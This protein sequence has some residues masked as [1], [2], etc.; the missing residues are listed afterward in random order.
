MNAG[1]FMSAREGRRLPG[2]PLHFSG[3][4]GGQVPPSPSLALSSGPQCFLFCFR[5]SSPSFPPRVTI[6]A[7]TSSF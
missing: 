7:S 1:M 4:S 6:D 5:P 3:S 2:V